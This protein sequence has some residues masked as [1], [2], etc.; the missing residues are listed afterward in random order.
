MGMSMV[1][2]RIA[3]YAKADPRK[4]KHAP[5]PKR[6][7]DPNEE[8]VGEEAVVSQPFMAVSPRPRPAPT[9]MEKA[10]KPILGA[11]AALVALGLGLA[12]FGGF[13]TGRSY[14]DA[15]REYERASQVQ[16][17]TTPRRGNAVAQ[18]YPGN[19]GAV[20]PVSLADR[21][22]PTDESFRATAYV[23]KK[24]NL[25]NASGECVIRGGEGARDFGECLR[26][27]GG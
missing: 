21:A 18:E 27:Q 8:M 2:R 25:P 19:G 4:K 17:S 7:S 16:A 23:R 22:L 12:V 11:V 13:G 26:R 10:R 14:A 3:G 24:V 20:A 6:K 1:R 5:L 15:A 9:L